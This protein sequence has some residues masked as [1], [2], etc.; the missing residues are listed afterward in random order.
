M[1]SRSTLTAV[2]VAIAVMA[3]IIELVRRRQLREEY[4]LLWL[5]TGGLMVG[6]AI[7]YTPLIIVTRA[8]GLTD[9]NVTLFFFGLIFLLVLNI[10]YSVKIS[11]LANQVKTLAQQLALHE[12]RENEPRTD[13]PDEQA[14]VVPRT[15]TDGV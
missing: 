11:A 9:A 12:A 6:V 8:I 5:I 15:P 14:D 13:G 7:W 10:Y 2:A 1:P 3:F 4:S